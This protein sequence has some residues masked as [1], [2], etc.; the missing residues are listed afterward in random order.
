MAFFFCYI[1]LASKNCLLQSFFLI[2]KFLQELMRGIIKIQIFQVLR[3]LILGVNKFLQTQSTW[4]LIKHLQVHD[5]MRHFSLCQGVFTIKKVFLILKIKSNHCLVHLAKYYTH[6]LIPSSKPPE[7]IFL[8]PEVYMILHCVPTYVPTVSFADLAHA[9]QH[10]T[11]PVLLC[12]CLLFQTEQLLLAK[13]L[14]WVLQRIP[15]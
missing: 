8:S 4:P 14:F 13:S 7:M 6:P 1:Y 3:D 15:R 2:F 10:G 5:V 9:I 12:H 11:F